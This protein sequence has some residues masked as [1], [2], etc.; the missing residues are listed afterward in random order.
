MSVWHTFLDMHFKRE[1]IGNATL[2]RWI[3]WCSPRTGRG[4]YL[5]QFVGSDAA[6]EMHDHPKR[7]IS[8]GLSGR[9]FE[10]TPDGDAQPFQAPFLRSFKPEH[11]HRQLMWED[12]TCWTLVY[13]GPKVREWGF[14][15]DDGTWQHWSEYAKNCSWW[16][17]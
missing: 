12:E 4:I 17:Q 13:V 15:L 11:I 9:Y 7:F 6:R 14:W 2:H 16:V 5:H 8:L 3:I 1:E 10:Q